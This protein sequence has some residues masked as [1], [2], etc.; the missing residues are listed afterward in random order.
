MK[1]KKMILLFCVLV[2]LL[3]CFLVYAI[4]DI[5][6]DAPTEPV[7]SA[8]RNPTGISDDLIREIIDWLYFRDMEYEK[9][10]D[11]SFENKLDF[12]R[13][14][15]HNDVNGYS[16]QPLHA[17]FDPENYYFV[18]GYYNATHEQAYKECDTYCCS[19]EY[20]WVRFETPEDIPDFY[21]GEPF[22]VAFQINKTAFCQDM[23]PLDREIPALEYF[24][25]FTPLFADGLNVEKPIPF[26]E[27]FVYLK[28][29]K[30]K[31]V[32]YGCGGMQNHENVT[33]YCVELD[34]ICY[35]PIK[36]DSD[37]TIEEETGKYNEALKHIALMGKYSANDDNGNLIHYAL[38]KIDDVVNIL[39]NWKE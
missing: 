29:K 4:S 3:L 2:L 33:I 5:I 9:I 28:W 35:L 15:I 16:P 32:Y 24:Q 27:H 11:F 34:G 14:G 18:C 12:F 30:G 37:G 6:C 13:T 8:Y 25:L 1:K 22:V 36:M 23:L 7:V 19:S 39:M 20:L 17:Q 38:V 26:N 21:N 10:Y 31:T